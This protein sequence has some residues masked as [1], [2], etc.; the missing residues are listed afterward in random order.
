MIVGRKILMC[1][2]I[3]LALAAS[4]WGDPPATVSVPVSGQYWEREAGGWLNYSGL[5]TF[6]WKESPGTTGEWPV[7]AKLV[8][9]AWCLNTGAGYTLI[10]FFS[11]VVKGAA[12]STMLLFKELTALD[13]RGQPAFTAPASLAFSIPQETGAPSVVAIALGRR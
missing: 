10:G 4:S 1:A 13:G 8:A 11:D 3:A 6:T 7:N 12:G 9:Q 2:V 5:I